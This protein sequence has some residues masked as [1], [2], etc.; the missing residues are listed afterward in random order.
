MTIL[1]RQAHIIDPASPFHSTQQDVLIENGSIKQ[2]GQLQNSSADKIIEHEN[3]HLSPGWVDLFVNFCDPGYEYKET[4]ET[5]MDAAAAGGFTEVMVLPNTN[6]V[7]SGKSQVEYLVQRS[8]Y[9]AVSIHPLGSVTKQTEG[10]ELAEMYDMK[11]AGAVAF[12]DGVH[13]VQSAGLL[14]KALQYVK[15]FNGTVIQIPDDKTIGTHG[16]I[17]EGIVSTRLGLPGKPV[18]AEEIQVARDIKL[19]RYA[20]SKLHFTGVTSPKSLEYINRSKESGIAVTCSVTPAHLY[21]SDEDLQTYDTNLKLYPPLR[22]ITERDA[23]KAAV[24]NGSVD[25]IASHHQPHEYDSKVCEFEYAKA[26]MI[27]LE[28][29][30]GVMGAVFGEK[31][32]AE[33][34][35][36][37]VSINPRRVLDL[38]MP[39][40]KEGEPAN[41][42]MFIPQAT[43]VFTEDDIRSKSK[44]SAFVGRELKGKVV[45]IINNNQLKLN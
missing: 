10:K 36:E 5:G 4:L 25:C 27:G 13:P 38:E 29:S 16:L 15:A 28:T 12:T 42:T 44:N 24:L 22:A 19:T 1:I 40:I 39:L 18:L 41:V 7:V 20:E 2:I 6:P 43:Y 45:G 11:A 17:N 30:Y 32:S 23:L 26:G 33:K 3:L 8:K 31:L 21:F 34:W 35:V 9:A 37:L 14:L